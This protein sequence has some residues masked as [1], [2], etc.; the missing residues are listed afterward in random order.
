MKHLLIRSLVLSACTML[1]FS[2]CKKVLEEE[3]RSFYDPNF[4]KTEKG[5]QGGITSQYAHLR[6]IYGQPYFYNS[7]ETGTDE[8]TWASSA[9]ANF[10]DADL[11]GVGNLTPASSRSDVL[12]GT[13]FS[14]INTASGIIENAAA[15]GTFPASLIAE[16]RFFRAFDYFLLVQTFGGV[17]LDL[18]AGELKFNTAPSRKSVRNTVPEVYTKAVFPDLLQAVDELPAT[19]RVTGGVTKTVARL[20][21]AKAYLTYGWWLQNPNNIPTYPLTSRTDPD[22]HD[23]QWYFQK[24]YDIAVQAIDNPGPY[25]LENTFYDLHVGGNDRN[26]EMLLY[27]DHTQE[28]EFYNGAC[29]ACFDAESGNGRNSASWMVTFNYT[30]IR[31]SPDATGTGAG[32]S[33]VQREAAQALGRPYTRMAPTIGAITN[34]FADKTLDSRYDGTF[35]TV[36]RGNW[37]KGGTTNATLYNANGLPV[38]PGQ[39]IL[40]FLDDESLAPAITYPSGATF[41]GKPAANNIGAGQ[42]NGRAD[43]VIT[44]R[45]I[46]RI[47]YPNLWK[48]GVY[49]TDNGA[50]LGQPNATSTRPFKIAKFSELY[51]IAAEAAVKGATPAA[52]KSA[53]DLINVIRA[54]AGKWKFSNKENAPL[55]ADNSAAMVAATPATIDINYILAERSREY[56]GEGHRWFDLVRTQK[57][58]ELAGTYEIAGPAYGNHT[59]QLV[60]RTIE[61]K[62][63]LRPIPQDQMDRM[64][65]TAEEKAAYQN[66][67]YQ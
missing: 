49:R 18:G 53:R 13:A 19:P 9:D 63:Y 10:K 58:N 32:V 43:W 65:F 20:Y 23:A 47:V 35:T 44:P 4:F 36:Y 12:W 27:A 26:K 59:P 28:S 15:V 55:I 7:L 24:A 14:N 31:S 39:P 57:W 61:P 41:P 60:T 21:L 64:E 52:G 56:F 66:P 6:F 2:R 45:A 33:S 1:L 11:S 50:G 25:G 3:P 34:T 62:H 46:S 38:T 48:I 54:R 51:F 22:G 8:Y 29:L 30:V 42:I 67:G 37:P 17:P 5:V 16:A 40:T